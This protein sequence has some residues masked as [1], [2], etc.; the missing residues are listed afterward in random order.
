MKEPS[1]IILAVIPARGGSKGI[2]NKNIRLLRGK[3]MIVYAI[4]C[5]QRCPS[6]NKVWVTTDSR[7]I[8]RIAK[9]SGACVPSLRPSILAEDTTPMMPVLQHALSEAEQYFHET[10]RRLV[11][12]DPTAPLRS[13]ADV[14]RALQVFSQN[15]CDAVVSGNLAHRNPYF[16]MVRTEG[17]YVKLVNE[18]T[19][20]IGRR[21]DA[22]EIFDLNTVVW[23][24][25]RDAICEGKRLPQR[26]LLYRVPRDRAIDLDSE[27]D[28]RM[29]ECFM[30]H[31]ESCCTPGET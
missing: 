14:E 24:Y 27:L 21:Q 8:A 6:I 1:G 11:L 26:T 28:L 23:I 30:D 3:P 4:E 15:P 12:L 16:N 18:T 13:V 5:A 29:I 7:T 20:D 19:R 2:P 22:P 10:V 17:P 31:R 25:S 9:Q